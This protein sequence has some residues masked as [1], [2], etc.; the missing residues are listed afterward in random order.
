MKTEKNKKIEIDT[1]KGVREE[2]NA[3]KMIRES[4]E[5]KTTKLIEYSPQAKD[6]MTQLGFD[7]ENENL[8]IVILNETLEGELGCILSGKALLTNN[9]KIVDVSTWLDFWPMRYQV[10]DNNMVTDKV[11]QKLFK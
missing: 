8:F 11:F 4:I 3:G 6:A 7:Y 2:F 10:V 5:V 1:F 9:E